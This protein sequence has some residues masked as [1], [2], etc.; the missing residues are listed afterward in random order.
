MMTRR[1]LAAFAAA[2]LA[3]ACSAPP[4]ERALRYRMPEDPPTLDPFRA[5]EDNSL[6][7][8]NVIFDGL[9][10]YVPGTLDVRPAVAESW[11]VSPDGLVYT[12]TLRP[13]VRFHS[14]REVTAGDVV[15][16]IRRALSVQAKSEKRSFFDALKGAADF[17]E[18]RTADLAGVQALDPRRVAIT[19]TYPYEKFLT[20]LAGEAGSILPEEVYSD[21][22]Q[23][24]L[25]HPV[26]CG[27]F[28]FAAR[29]RGTSLTLTRFAEHWKGAGQPGAISKIEFR[30]IPNVATTLEEYKAGTVDFDF[31]LPPGQRQQIQRELASDFHHGQ[32]LALMFLCFNHAAGPFKDNA[33]LRR[34]IVYAID[35]DFIANGL[36]EGKD[37]AATG[38][39]PPAML[40]HDPARGPLAHDPDLA[41]GLLAQAGFPGGKGFPEIVYRT[42]ETQSF[43]RIAE[44]LQAD[45]ARI[46]IKMRFNT[47]D[48]SAFMASMQ[49][50]RSDPADGTLFR[51][52]WFPDWP[53]PDSFLGGMLLTDGGGNYGHY[54]NPD[55]DQILERARREPDRGKRETLYREAETLALDDAALVPLYW[56]GQDL[57]LKPK[58]KGLKLS[59]LGVF[60]IAWEEITEVT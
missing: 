32:R 2:L 50:G 53:D 45:L 11:T 55:L 5:G 17:W 28:R 56:Y 48:F 58:Y 49:S 31:E 7:Y 54:H 15:Y 27:P 34:A 36:Q 37:V 40:G 57:L 46:G 19:L 8:I 18:G 30:M 23:E 14:G 59:P 35:R 41:A 44:R 39:I 25:E 22:N 10:E 26:G 42:N 13:N 29:E 16:S 43:H 6:V 1:I 38:I 60:G 21:P 3:A 24:Y 4:A 51:M 20:I 52:T 12:F 47:S 9:V 33:L